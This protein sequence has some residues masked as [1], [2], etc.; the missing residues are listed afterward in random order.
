MLG[1]PYRRLLRSAGA[2]EN[3]FVTRE[4]H[5]EPPPRIPT[6]Y[7][8]PGYA[9]IK[10]TNL[11]LLKRTSDYQE[12]NWKNFKMS[13]NKFKDKSSISKKELESLGGLLS[14]CSHVVDG[15]R[16]HYRWFYDLYKVILNNNLQR[17]KLSV[18]AREVCLFVCGI[19]LTSGQLFNELFP[20]C[21]RS[22]FSH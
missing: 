16:T 18:A 14:H 4:L 15:G 6:G 22:C 20:D 19:S 9:G 7:L 12:T 10:V 1:P 13:V 21:T 5:Q 17:A 11:I 8:P 3:L 2:T